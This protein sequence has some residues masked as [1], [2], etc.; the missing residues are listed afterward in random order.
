[1]VDG[2]GNVV[3][4]RGANMSGLED[5]TAFGA[6]HPWDSS[7]LTTSSGSYPN[8]SALTSWK[9]NVVRLPI[10]EGPWLHMTVTNPNG[11]SVNLD[12]SGDYQSTVVNSVKQLNALGIYV[13]LDLHG[14]APAM[15]NE[16]AQN[17]F[18]DAD[19][20]VTFWTQVADTFKDQPGVLF[21]AFNEP[22]LFDTS[23]C[24][25]GF[26]PVGSNFNKA[27]RDGALVANQ[28]AIDNY[29]AGNYAN[30]EFLSYSWTIVGYQAIVN[31]I[32]STGATNVIILGGNDYSNDLT[33]WTQYPPSDPIGQLALA[34]HAYPSTWG[35]DVTGESTEFT[36]AQSIAVL[37]APDVPV[38]ITEMGGPVGAGASTWFVSNMLSVIDQEGW[39]VTAW[40]WN[41]WDGSNVGNNTLIQNITN[42]APTVGEGQVFYN[43]TVNHK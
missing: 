25:N 5:G 16:D 31:A 30:D 15:F 4:L 17:P 11:T 39:S 6:Q 37:N 28:Y 8:F 23:H 21:E 35:Y 26:F 18:M 33:W 43:W 10:A 9:I 7:N 40:T 34:Y 27:I 2:K 42:Y 36:A 20:S 24:C 19:H 38:I 13:I 14:A 41:P 12:P 1:L 3:Q 22:Y 29:S 32:R